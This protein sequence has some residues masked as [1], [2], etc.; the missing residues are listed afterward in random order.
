MKNGRCRLHGGLSTGAKTAEGIERIRRA[1]T[2]HGQYSK[3]ARTEQRQF[4]EL[5]QSFQSFLREIP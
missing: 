3:A 5:L 1:K 2:V 4:R